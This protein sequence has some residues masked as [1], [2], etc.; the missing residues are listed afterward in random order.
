MRLHKYSRWKAV[1]IRPPISL[2]NA[3]DILGREHG[4]IINRERSKGALKACPIHERPKE[5]IKGFRGR[6]DEHDAAMAAD[7]SSV[8]TMTDL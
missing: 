7:G 5:V 4:V 6:G 2:L 8:G 3:S 1:D